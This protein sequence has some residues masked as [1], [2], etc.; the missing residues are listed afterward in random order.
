MRTRAIRLE[1]HGGPE[2]MRFDDVDIPPPGPG[3]ALVRHVAV[4]VNYI[5]TYH[6]SGLYPIASFPSGLG[7]EAAG[8]V[9][10]VGTDVSDLAP[11]DRVAYAGGPLGAYAVQRVLPAD[12]LVRLPAGIPFETAAAMMLKG[13]TAEYLLR[14][15]FVVKAGD[16][17]L[18]H[19]AAGG[20]GLML[21]QWAKA[22]GARVL[23]TVG[24][25]AKA[26]LAKAYGCDVPI[27]YTRDDF[28][29][30][31]RAETDGVGVAVVYDAVGQD[32][33][34]K[35][36]DCLRPRG[37]LA[38]YGQ[39]SGKVAPFDPALLAAKGSLYLTRPSLFTYT[40]RR[41]DLL[42]S[43]NALFD[44]VQS[45]A[46]RVNVTGKYA[47]AEAALA[48]RDLESRITTGS[49]VLVP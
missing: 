33:F 13:M 9:E 6:R 16:T 32:T 21:C 45:G 30:R 28:V 29:A 12:R 15:T 10:A 8:F 7:L 46:V 38:L 2:V 47:L 22:L 4:G 3:E 14:R 40:A 24:N 35:S 43:A 20:V 34:L 18:V 25:E 26:A 27:L 19:A 39:A 42:E 41:V 1:T 11:G 37:V 36:L 49:L 31:V 23:G 44:V 17:I 5:D 48:H